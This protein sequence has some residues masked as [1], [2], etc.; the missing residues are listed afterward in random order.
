MIHVADKH[1]FYEHLLAERAATWEV[2]EGVCFVSCREHRHWGLA[3]QVAGQKLTPQQLREALAKRFRETER[4]NDYFLF[5]DARQALVIWRSLPKG[6]GAAVPLD[7]I[8]GTQLTLAGLEH[9]FG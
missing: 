2:A 6:A 4:F 8:R 7:E 5:F 9:L 1:V 3:L